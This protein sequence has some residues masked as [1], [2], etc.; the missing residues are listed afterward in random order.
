M[1][2][3]KDAV[4]TIIVAAGEG[5]RL[6]GKKP[7]Q[8][9]TLHGMTVLEHTIA[10]FQKTKEV[11]EIV[12]VLPGRYCSFY[13]RKLAKR[14][15]K[16]THVVVGGKKRA[17]SVLSG[18]RAAGIASIYLIH[19]GVRPFIRREL[20]RRIIAE[21]AKC[22]AAIAAIKVQDTVKEADQHGYIVRTVDREMLYCA[23]TPQGFRKDVMD[24]IMKLGAAE[25]SRM[26]DDSMLAERLGFKVRIVETDKANLKITTASDLKLA[27]RML[28][29]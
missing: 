9:F 22:G 6:S 29:I 15:N 28:D 27:R 2:K 14:F 5:K 21:T 8:F 23:Q 20:I 12:V 26:T 13:S 7:K 11:S 10:Q 25:R 1:S 18:V 4:K 16:V 17:D 24:G 19:D 3:Q